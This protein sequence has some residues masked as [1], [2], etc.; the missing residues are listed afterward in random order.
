MLGALSQRSYLVAILVEFSFSPYV[1]RRYVVDIPE[2]Q[3]FSAEILLT[4]LV[5]LA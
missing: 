2:R 1:S 4:T 5:L 3:A